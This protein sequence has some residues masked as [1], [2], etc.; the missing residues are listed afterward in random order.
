M[1]STDINKRFHPNIIEYCFFSA[2]QGT[3]PK[4]YFIEVYKACLNKC[5]TK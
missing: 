4:T 5:K 3:L 1:D 2:I